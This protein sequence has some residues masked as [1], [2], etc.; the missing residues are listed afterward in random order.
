[1]LMREIHFPG[2]EVLNEEHIANRP[3]PGLL[4]QWTKDC[5]PTEWT[6]QDMGRWETSNFNTYQDPTEGHFPSSLIKRPRDSHWSADVNIWSLYCSLVYS[7]IMEVCQELF[8][9]LSQGILYI[10]R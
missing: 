1:M 10:F 3:S 4:C 2:S 7:I 6:M 8:L 5:K 9:Y